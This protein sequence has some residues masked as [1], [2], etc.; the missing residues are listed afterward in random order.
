MHVTMYCYTHLLCIYYHYMYNCA[1]DGDMHVS[2]M[3]TLAS[4]D[5]PQGD[6][7]IYKY[8]TAYTGKHA[9]LYTLYTIYTVHYIHC[10]CTLYTI[11]T[12]ACSLHAMFLPPSLLYLSDPWSAISHFPSRLFTP[13]CAWFFSYLLYNNFQ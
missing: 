1:A 8:T 10:K 13:L 6:V 3:C 7:Y 11:Y 12:V 5:R 9:I 2:V 4:T